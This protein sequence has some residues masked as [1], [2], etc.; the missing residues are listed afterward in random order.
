MRE[1]MHR[2]RIGEIVCRHVHR[3]DRGDGAG[4]GVGD[5]LFQLRQL[6]AHG[7][8]VTQARRHLPHQ[9]GHLHA[10]LDE[11]EN[12]VDEQQ[13]VAMLVVAKVLGHGQRRMADAETRARGFVH[14]AEHHHHVGQHAGRASC[15]GRAP[16]LR[17]AFADAAKDAHAF[18][19]PT[20]L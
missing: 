13:H 6:G 8:L 11:T 3:L 12:I 16:R 5:A 7:R 17:A 19:C 4:I 10:G 18:C 9:A 2:R 20:M 14:L 15:R 1:G